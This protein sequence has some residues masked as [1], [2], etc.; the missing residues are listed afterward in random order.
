MNTF[1][2]QS[3]EIAAPFAT[4]FRYI[5]DPENLPE[6]THAFKHIAGDRATMET[7]AGTVQVGLRVVASELQGTID[8]TMT[9]P[10]GGVA[11]AASRVIP[12]GDRSIYTF[13]LEAPPVP[14]ERLEG[15]LAEQS[16][17]LTTELAALAHRLRDNGSSHA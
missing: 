1:D 4:A 10:D 17:I 5:A 12:H 11:K 8:W 2:V 6:W 13:V 14:L 7:P 9:F 3:T 16:R 15:A